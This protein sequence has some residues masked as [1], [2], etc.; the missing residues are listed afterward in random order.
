[1][2]QKNILVTIWYS[3]PILT[4]VNISCGT[5]IYAESYLLAEDSQIL[6]TEIDDKILT[7]QQ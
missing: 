6:L 7:E 4:K 2:D 5:S 1:M 3:D